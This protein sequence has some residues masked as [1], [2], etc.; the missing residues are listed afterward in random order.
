MMPRLARVFDMSATELSFRSRG[1][2]RTQGERLSV[3]LKRP[4][5]TRHDLAGALDSK[6]LDGALRDAVANA[7]WNEAAARLR[8]IVLRRPARFVIDFR[9]ARPLTRAIIQRWPDTPRTSARHADA[10]LAGRHDILGYPA[11]SFAH[12]GHTIDWHYDPVHRRSAP[13]RFWADVPF[14]DPRC[15]DHK[16]IWEIN[17]QQ[18]FLALGRAFWLTG[19]HRYAAR[20]VDDIRDWLNANPPL[21]GINWASMLELGFR[22]LSW[23]TAMHFLLGDVES[24]ERDTRDGASTA[25]R[26][27]QAD[28][29]WLLDVLVGLNRQLTHV[30]RHLS[31]YFSPNTHLTGEALALYVVGVAL[32]ELARSE[33]WTQLG[34]S[35]LLREIESQIHEDGGHAELSTCYHR[36]TLDFYNLALITAELEGDISAMTTFR[37]AV[38]RLRD[39]LQAFSGTDG[40]IPVIGDEDG[41]QLWS[42]PDREPHDVSDSLALASA[43]TAT[44]NGGDLPEAALWLAWSSRPAIRQRRPRAV[45]SWSSTEETVLSV[46]D[47]RESG[48]VV[49]HTD[50]GD[51]LTFDTGP[52]GFLNGGH[53]HADALSITLS[54]HSRPFL[55]DPGSATYTMDPELRTRLRESSSH[56]TLTLGGRSSAVPQGP[57]HWQTRA[58][59]RLESLT[60][61]PRFMIAEGTHDGYQPAEHRRLIVHG[62]GTGWLIADFVTGSTA[63]VD[64]FWHFD[65]AWLVEENAAGS[66]LATGPTGTRA[67]LLCSDGV[68][69]LCRGGETS[70]WCSPRYGSLV[71]TFTAN[72]HRHDF[73]GRPLITWIG[74]DD[75]APDAILEDVTVRSQ[76]DSVAAVRIAHRYGTILNLVRPHTMRQARVTTVDEITTDARVLQL[77]TTRGGATTMSALDAHYVSTPAFDV[78]AAE[79]IPDLWLKAGPDALELWSTAPPSSLRVRF[80]EEPQTRRLRLNGRDTLGLIRNGDVVILSSSWNLAAQPGSATARRRSVRRAY[81]TNGRFMGTYRTE[82]RF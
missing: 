30:E 32:P 43:L 56:N 60:T 31:R 63:P 3:S 22:S 35:I 20:I 53:A 18:Y 21:L 14:L 66:L 16:V 42:F 37:D 41:G 15:G 79:P 11:L 64:A 27:R 45:P 44:P 1:M 2:L 7:R 8:A 73:T 77:M 55:I 13:L 12:H 59:A 46:H 65:P 69:R 39:Y 81:E 29:T 74:L 58:T 48:Y 19:D 5:W 24:H 10:V 4:A 6:L 54:L 51:R 33:R 61:N 80:T 38:N 68:S 82:G 78:D 25:K 36:Y 40:T 47:L 17:R 26:S 76:G 9:Q 67:W 52:H 71:P 75:D 72:V 28:D 34:K 62:R 50:C 23:T 70:G 49:A 57:F